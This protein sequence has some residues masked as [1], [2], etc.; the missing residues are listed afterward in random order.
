MLFRS[1]RGSIVLPSISS[2]A[3]DAQAFLSRAT[4]NPANFECIGKQGNATGQS[5]LV[6][7]GP[8]TSHFRPLC[9]LRLLPA[10]FDLTC[11][12]S[13]LLSMGFC[14]QD[15]PRLDRLIVSLEVD[16]FRATTRTGAIDVV[17]SNTVCPPRASLLW[18]GMLYAD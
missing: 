3:H 4:C 2:R 18:R 17:L 10:S 14:N 15:S 1:E 13:Q 6:S 8:F 5:D 9:S 7:I 16:D 12:R 11:T